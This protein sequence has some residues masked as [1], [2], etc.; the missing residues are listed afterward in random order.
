MIITYIG[1][2]NM[3]SALIGGLARTGEHELRVADPDPRVRE[4]LEAE[5]GV[6]T[7]ETGADAVQGADMI[8]LA[9]KPQVL[10]A[11]LR[12]LR[13]A[14]GPNQCV[15]SVAAG[16]T[17]ATIRG[18]LGERQPLV[19]SMPNTP[20][21]LGEG[22]TGLY[23]DDRCSATD[24]AAAETIMGAG[25]QAVWVDE[26]GLIDA[27]TAVSGSGPAYYYLFTEA[28]ADAGRALGLPRETALK[29]AVQTAA[30]AGAMLQAG[31]A[32]PV[33]L[34]RRVTSPGGTTQAAIGA[35]EAGGLR[36]LVHAAAEAAARRGKELATGGGD[37]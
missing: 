31:D 18:V 11:V 19:R 8:V 26:E 4:R 1:G 28:L 25:G 35:L 2:G 20:A 37:A 22:I 7:F 12:D 32:D 34:R 16:I 5:H 24:R 30:G 10:P 15:L 13:G 6:A 27:V 21:L 36:D 9:V 17:L 23:A 14:L 3:A 29:L 33:E